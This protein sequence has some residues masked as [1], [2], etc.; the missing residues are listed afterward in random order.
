M[1]TTAGARGNHHLCTRRSPPV[2]TYHPCAYSDASGWA[3]RPAPTSCSSCAP[4]KAHT[5]SFLTQ[6]TYT[7]ARPHSLTTN[8]RSQRLT[9]IQGLL[10]RMIAMTAAADTPT[11][12]PTNGLHDRDSS[13]DIQHTC[14]ACPN[15]L[16]SSLDPDNSPG[17]QDRRQPPVASRQ[18]QSTCLTRPVSYH[19]ALRER[20]SDHS[21]HRY[22]LSRRQ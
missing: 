13:P 19:Q 8:K 5:Y 16:P 20:S 1:Q 9:G 14:R 17:T 6:L 7:K 2:T 22:A 10:L 18:P 4:A 15:G 3:G 11:D 12:Q 21:I